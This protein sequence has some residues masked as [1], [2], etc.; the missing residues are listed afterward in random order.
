MAYQSSLPSMLF[1]IVE[2]KVQ[3]RLW[4]GS[5]WTW[6]I[7]YLSNHFWFL[8]P[9]KP[10]K[11]KNLTKLSQN[12]TQ[13]R[14]KCWPWMVCLRL[15]L[16][17]LSI[18]M[19]EMQKLHLCG[20]LR[21][22]KTLLSKSRSWFQIQRKQKQLLRLH[23]TRMSQIQRLLRLL[24]CLDSLK[25]KQKEAWENVTTTKREPLIGSWIIWMSLT[26]KTI[27]QLPNQLL[28]SSQFSRMK[29]HRKVTTTFMVRSL[30][31]E[32]AFTPGTMSATSRKKVSGYT[33]TM[34]KL[35]RLMSHLLVKVTCT[36]TQRLK[37]E[38]F[39]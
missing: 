11:L 17:M 34:P 1:T 6:K 24:R 28:M 33:S 15:Q 36:F 31:W 7:P 39:S 9:R 38:N 30:I 21:T 19:M 32:Q 27:N 16:S 35:Q 10:N 2:D 3:K 12:L 18:I 29:N 22:S 25:H 8:I 20:S 26:V 23:L 37:N 4:N 5:I 13:A 14:Y